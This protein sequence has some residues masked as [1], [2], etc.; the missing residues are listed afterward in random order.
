M[1]IYVLQY[2]PSA[3]R[4]RVQRGLQEAGQTAVGEEGGEGGFPQGLLNLMCV[5]DIEKLFVW[6]Q[7][8]P[9][10]AGRFDSS[11]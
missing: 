3:R 10:V 2:A 1:L 4:S 9:V 11:K 8:L 5:L 6:V 7:M